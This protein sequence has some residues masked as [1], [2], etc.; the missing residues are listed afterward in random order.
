MTGPRGEQAGK[1]L[2][3]V[4]QLGFRVCLCSGL[5]GLHIP[6][7]VF[8]WG[9]FRQSLWFCPEQ[10]HAWFRSYPN[11]IDIDMHRRNWPFSFQVL[12]DIARCLKARGAR[13]LMATITG[14]VYTL[15]DKGDA[16]SA[17]S[18]LQELSAAAL[19]PA[20][21]DR[22]GQRM[23][24]RVSAWDD[25]DLR[26]LS[27]FDGQTRGYLQLA[28]FYSDLSHSA[29]NELLDHSA[30][31]LFFGKAV[32]QEVAVRV[33]RP[34]AN[35]LENCRASSSVRGEIN[36]DRKWTSLRQIL[37]AGTEARLP[38]GTVGALLRSLVECTRSGQPPQL[39]TAFAE[40]CALQREP[41]CVG[42]S[43]GLA[44]QLSAFARGVRNAAAHAGP[45]IG[46]EGVVRAEAAVLGG[47]DALLRVI[48]QSFSPFRE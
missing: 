39:A 10:R 48:L 13:A 35:H 20:D 46:L 32:E 6:L 43:G 29:G 8:V 33:L 16:D 41:E 11:R 9:G 30:S 36:A 34:L 5:F 42:I 4:G 2:Q 44:A 31:I 26:V 47:D 45:Y 37:A 18:Y 40:F 3:Q 23:A 7:S 21:V 27:R 15:V 28:S 25:M 14:D 22:H 1:P 12:L 38:L 17:V 24:L 19:S